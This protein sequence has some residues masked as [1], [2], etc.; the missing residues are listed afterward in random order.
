MHIQAFYPTQPVCMCFAW[1]ALEE[2]LSVWASIYFTLIHLA[3]RKSPIYWNTK[4]TQSVFCLDDS[5]VLSPP[6]NLGLICYPV[7]CTCS[8]FIPRIATVS[9]GRGGATLSSL[10]AGGGATTASLEAMQRHPRQSREAQ[11]MS[12]SSE[13]EQQFWQ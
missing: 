8:V 11:V 9:T 5:L 7:V 1:M 13:V 4:Y 10:E 12:V 2:M 6:F 3:M